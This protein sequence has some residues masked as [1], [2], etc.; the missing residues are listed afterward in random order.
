MSPDIV[1]H[2]KAKPKTPIPPKSDNKISEMEDKISNL[3]SQINDLKE[4]IDFRNRYITQL[5]EMSK[6]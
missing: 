2:K 3:L 4:Q 6:N 5:E 1:E